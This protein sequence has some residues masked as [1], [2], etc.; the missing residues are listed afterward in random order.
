[1]GWT[2]AFA[3]GLGNTDNVRPYGLFVV[4][5]DLYLTFTDLATGAEIR[6]TGSRGAWWPVNE[7]SWGDPLNR[8]ASYFDKGMAVFRFDLYVASTSSEGGEVWMLPL[9]H[10]TLLPVVLKGY[11]P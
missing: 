7:S 9:A 4:G 3:N 6:R 11:A 1:M 10:H 2:P 5:D 8:D